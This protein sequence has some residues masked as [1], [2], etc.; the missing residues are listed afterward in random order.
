MEVEETPE[1]VV[2]GEY[3][4]KEKRGGREG[5]GKEIARSS[6]RKI[7]EKRFNFN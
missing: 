6:K 7:K 5:D 1:R 3:S 4:R 2:N